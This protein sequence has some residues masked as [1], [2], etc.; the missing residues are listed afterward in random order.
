MTSSVGQVAGLRGGG[1]SKGVGVFA[2]AIAY[3]KH[4]KNGEAESLCL[5]T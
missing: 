1:W 4:S 2:I 3:K 5:L